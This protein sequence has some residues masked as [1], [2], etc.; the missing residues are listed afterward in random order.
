MKLLNRVTLVVIRFFSS[1][2]MF[3]EQNVLEL[4]MSS[5]DGEWLWVMIVKC[6]IIINTGEITTYTKG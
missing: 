4:Q 5:R 6:G 3:F 1:F 2:I